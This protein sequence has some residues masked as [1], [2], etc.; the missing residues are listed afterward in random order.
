M[1]IKELTNEEFKNFSSKYNQKSIYQ[2]VEYAHV[3]NKQKFDSMYVG[4]IDDNHIVAASLLLIEK[5]RRF[6]YAYAPKGFLIDYLDHNLVSAFTTELKKFLGKKGVVAVKLNPMII[7]NTYDFKYNV[8]KKDAYFDSSFEF[9]QKEGYYHYGF[10]EFFEALKPRYEAI[11]DISVPY[12]MVFKN[13]DKKLRTKIRSAEGRGIHIYKGDYDDLKYLYLQ[14]KFKYPRDLKY[15]EDCYTEFSKAKSIEF[16]YAKLDTK[17]YLKLCQDKYTKQESICL[18]MNE[19][20]MKQTDKKE[21]LIEK[22]MA[23]DKLLDTYKRELIKATKMLKNNE[24]GIILA[25]AMI[26]KNSDTVYLYM[27]GY[28]SKYKNFNA[29]HLLL[30]KLCE[31]Y[32]KAGYKYFNLGGVA[33][34]NA[35]KS[36][37]EGLKNFKCSFNAKVIEYLGDLEL[38]TNN[39]L[40]FMYRN[41]KPIQNI[42]KK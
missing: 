37:Y 38:I 4:L 24:F 27:D 20:L 9:L 15:Y 13:F 42:L 11:I 6:K 21:K 32:S 23:A 30:W 41:T 3:M 2:T 10:N 19:Q 34:I 31:R 7:K 25:S 39:T 35:G 8:F 40:Y 17:H 18:N 1:Y 16:F 33:G 28:D 26:I 36:D 5:I 14:T 22:K 12:Y 29:K